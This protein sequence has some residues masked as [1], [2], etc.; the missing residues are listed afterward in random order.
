LSNAILD[1]AEEA[2]RQKRF[3]DVIQLLGNHIQ[4]SARSHE[5]LGYSYGQLGNLKLT[6]KHLLEA[7]RKQNCSIEVFY[8]LGLLYVQLNK[9]S[10]TVKFL[11]QAIAKNDE[12]FEAHFLL[13]NTL[14]QQ[15]MF[16]SATDHYLKH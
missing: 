6:E 5:L 14:A 15:Q 11:R 2:F 4:T 12:F 7:S 13:G 10:L 16:Q 3:Q 8:Y 9:P 1:T